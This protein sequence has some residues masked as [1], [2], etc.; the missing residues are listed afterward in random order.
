[1][2][3][4]RLTESTLQQAFPKFPSAWD[5]LSSVPTFEPIN[6]VKLKSSASSVTFSSIPSTYSHLQ[7]RGTVKSNT[8]GAGDLSIRFNGD[9]GTNY[10]RH[11]IQANGSTAT[12][13]NA[14]I[15][16]TSIRIADNF[17]PPTSEGNIFGV[18]ILDILDYADINKLTTVKNIYGSDR[19][20][21][22]L[23]GMH[24]GFWNNTNAI[25]SIEIIGETS[26]NIFSSISLYGIK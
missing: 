23:F 18:F 24:S 2:A 20:G 12:A 25:N 7:I 16:Q 14:G 19:N 6:T 5:G 10:A 15:S 3:I 9:S 13:P 8:T 1:M 11:T 22:G 4:T 26:F 21:S 17:L